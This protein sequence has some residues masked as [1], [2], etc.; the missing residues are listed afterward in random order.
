MAKDKGQVLKSATHTKVNG[1]PAVA[2]VL[3]S[4][5]KITVPRAVLG[6]WNT[7][8]KELALRGT[9]LEANAIGDG[10]WLQAVAEAITAGGE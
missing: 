4:G 5:E 3:T 7:F 9:F 8:R 6:S 1:K 2:C 10:D